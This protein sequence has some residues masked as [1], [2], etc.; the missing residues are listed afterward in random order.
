VFLFIE[1][2]EKDFRRVRRNEASEGGEK[3]SIIISPLPEEALPAGNAASASGSLKMQGT[4]KS[5]AH[6]L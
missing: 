2:Y 4:I 1:I 6:S 5:L 3:F